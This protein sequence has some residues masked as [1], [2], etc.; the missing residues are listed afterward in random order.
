MPLDVQLLDDSFAREVAGLRL[1]EAPSPE[2]VDELRALWARHGVLVFRRQCLSERELA[3]F[4]AGFGRLERVV[5]TDWASRSE[6]D[7]GV[8]SNLRDGEGKPIG[9]LGDGEINW[10]TDQSYIAEPA[11]GCLL[12]AIELPSTGGETCWADLTSAYRALPAALRRD[13]EGKEGVFSYGKRLAGYGA[14]DAAIS[15]EMKAKTPNVVHA[16]VQ[17]HPATGVPALYFDPTTTIGIRGMADREAAALIDELTRF[18]TRPEFVYRHRWQVGDVVMWDNGFLLHRRSEF[19]PSE[20]RLMKR[21]TVKLPR[22]LH[23]VPDGRLA[24]A[25]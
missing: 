13:V 14:V 5:R 12:H 11:T 10:H 17:R 3:R 24:E 15:A 21:T 8:L 7:I 22:A 23:I 18:A 4:S 9:G 2:T 6:P 19:A 20:R 16:L 25:A 1:W